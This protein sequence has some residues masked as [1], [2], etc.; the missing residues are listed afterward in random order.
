MA[1][2]F[3]VSD[4]H[5]KAQ[6]YAKLFQKIEEERPAAV[7]FGGDLLPSIGDIDG[8]ID[9][10]F[11][12]IVSLREEK[13][14]PTEFVVILGNDD[15]RKHEGRFLKAD[16]SGI[17][18]Y[19]AMRR[20]SIGGTVIFGYPFVPPT[21]FFLKDW[22][23]YD[24]SAYVDPGNVPPEDGHFTVDIERR[25][26]RFRTILQDLNDLTRGHD[27]S[28]AVM[29]FHAPPYDT[30]LDIA[31]IRGMMYDHAPLDHHV[32]SIAIRRFIEQRVPR[33]TLHGHIHESARLSGSWSQYIGG[34]RCLTAAHDGSELALI[35]FDPDSPDGAIR[36]LI[37]C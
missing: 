17:I 15:P 10:L 31:D 7:L 19:A 33:L 26:L 14:I 16:S 29:L 4:L 37:I 35:R 27:L 28:D 34:T 30:D 22:E 21:P 23:L 36:E 5:G 25:A 8:F 9:G 6:R 13:G 32:G 2:F 12:R 11:D 18:R 1:E 20:V 24:L 3:F